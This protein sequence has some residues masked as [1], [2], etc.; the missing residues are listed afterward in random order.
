MSIFKYLKYRNVLEKLEIQLE[1]AFSKRDYKRTETLMRRIE[2]V[3]RLWRA[4]WKY[5]MK[6]I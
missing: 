1:T 4:K 6:E 3:K 2:R 5:F